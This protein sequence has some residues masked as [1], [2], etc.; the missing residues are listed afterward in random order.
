MVILIPS[1]L[2]LP[3]LHGTTPVCSSE[4]KI[5]PVHNNAHLLNKHM[6]RKTSVQLLGDT[7]L[8][9]FFSSHPHRGCS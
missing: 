9:R 5:L 8:V 7:R 2:Q 1:V 4:T 3:M 6:L